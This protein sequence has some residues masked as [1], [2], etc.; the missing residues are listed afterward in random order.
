MMSMRGLLLFLPLCVVQLVHSEDS[1]RTRALPEVQVS[2][3]YASIPQFDDV[4]RSDYV[5]TPVLMALQEKSSQT[6]SDYL[7]HYTPAF[8]KESGNGMLSTLSLRG[9]NS[10]HTAVCWEDV[11]VNSRTMGQTDLSLMPLFFFQNVQLVPGG[12]SALFGDGAVGGAMT[13]SSY[14]AAK[15][16]VAVEVTSSYASFRT[17]FEGAKCVVAKNKITSHTALFYRQSE[18]DFKMSYRNVT[19]R[20]KNA[21]FYDYGFLQNLNFQIDRKQSLKVNLWHTFYDREIQ[22]MMQNNDDSTKY[23]SISNRSSR[24][25]VAYENRCDFPFRI[26]GGWLSDDQRYESHKIATDDWFVQSAVHHRWGKANGNHIDMRLTGNFHYIRPE[27][28]AYA[29]SVDEKRGELGFVSSLHLQDRWTLICAVDKSFVT[30]LR[31]PIAYSTDINYQILPKDVLTVGVQLARNLHTP[32]L[33]DRYWG[34]IDNRDLQPERGANLEL[35]VLCQKKVGIYGLSVQPSVYRNDVT[36][37]ILWL[38][39]GNIWKPVNVDRVLA[40]G[41]ECSVRQQFSHVRASETLTVCYAYNRTEVKAGFS[42]MK[43]FEGR[44]MPLLPKQ[45]L[46]VGFMGKVNRFF[47]DIQ[48]KCVG[49]RS[50]SDVFDVMENYFLLNVSAGYDFD[51]KNGHLLKVG[52]LVNNLLGEEYQTMPYRAMPKQNFEFHMSYLHG[53]KL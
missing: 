22:P 3:D 33:N 6:V 48:G 24:M 53:K 1:I 9:T 20:Q 39:R 17:F 43:P 32:T 26:Q 29:D 4:L 41:V 37:W 40:K 36:N 12:S 35:N 50:T 31:C 11:P 47:Y 10:S 25:V 21:S 44:Q 2:A 23:E 13:L 7:S 5:S 19:S 49:E 42:E 38:P 28:Y 51:L 8:V 16:T 45:T 15:D 46:S 30:D 14:V 27:V 34:N 52:V 18:N